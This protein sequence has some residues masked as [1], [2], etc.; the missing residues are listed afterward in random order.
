METKTLQIEGMSCGHCV[1]RVSKALAA[2]P[3][4]AV[5]QVTV[6]SAT[7]KIDPSANQLGEIGHVLDD[8]G[9]TLVGEGGARQ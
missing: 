7:V 5:E 6:G 8:L 4:V 1:A 3:G 2:M 9:F